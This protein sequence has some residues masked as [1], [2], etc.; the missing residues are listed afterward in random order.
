MINGGINISG[1]VSGTNVPE[2]VKQEIPPGAKADAINYKTVLTKIIHGKENR[3]NVV[4]LLKSYNDPNLAVPAAALMIVKQADQVVGKPAPDDIKLGT[5]AF[6][7][8]DL[9][10]IGKAAK[11]WPDVTEEEE[12]YIYQDTVQDYVSLGISKGTIDPIKL[13]KD[14]DPLLTPQQ[15]EI[16]TQVAQQQGIP[17]EP[18]PLGIAAQQKQSA[19]QQA[20]KN[21]A[22]QE[23]M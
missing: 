15:R 6:L 3:D 16:G 19:L 10:E 14:V 4:N 8:S 7:V 1:E 23:E 21:S 9:I 5:S 11:L 17:E 12:R 22:V 20:K 18:N 13:Q 2:V